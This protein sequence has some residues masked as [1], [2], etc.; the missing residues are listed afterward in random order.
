M[1]QAKQITIL[2]PVAP[3]LPAHLEAWSGRVEPEVELADCAVS[4]VD[5]GEVQ[6]LHID[7]SR[8]VNVQCV[9][10]AFA[11]L[12]IADATAQR[13]TAVGMRAPESSCLR[14]VIQN[15]RLTG[16]DFGAA[17]FEDCIFENIKFD[18]AGFRFATFKRVRFTDCV[19]READFKGAKLMNV[20]FSG[21]DLEG[22]N[23]ENATCQA[24]DLRSEP[25]T[26]IKGV[27]GLKG[28]VITSEQLIQIAPL[29]AIE[30]GL[31]ID[32]EA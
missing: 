21:C 4:N 30:V 27:L 10:A 7:S 14:A 26:G 24:V 29:L 3:K 28:A 18:E 22:A 31:V 8:L 12:Q 1:K 5:F 9:G 16:A 23:F 6:R 32:N 2:L 20:Y 13:L 17:L 25:L 19:L 11:K 15:S